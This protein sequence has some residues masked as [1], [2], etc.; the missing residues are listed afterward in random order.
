MTEITAE[1]VI[2]KVVPFAMSLLTLEQGTRV[3]LHDSPA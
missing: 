3:R 1:Q 2:D